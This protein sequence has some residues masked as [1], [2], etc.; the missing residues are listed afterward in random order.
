[1]KRLPPLTELRAFEAAA[2]HL[3]F[4]RAA[5]ELGVTPTA[6]SHQI[7]LLEQYCGKPLFRRRP[8]PMAL[9]W[10][11]QQLFPMVRDGFESFATA[12]AAVRA[13]S[14]SGG[15][16][17]TSTNALAARWLVP[18]LPLWRKEFPGIRLSIVGTDAVLDLR[19]GEADVA[20][21]YA[22]TPPSDM[23][24]VELARDT[25]HVVGSRSL[26]GVS[27]KAARPS[28]L[29]RFPIIECEWPPTDFGAPTWERWE[30]AARAK[31]RKVPSL[32]TSASF[33]FREELHAIE[34]VI[35]GQGIAILSDILV[36]RELAN[37]TLIRLSD[38]T[39][40]G[41][42]FFAVYRHG[43]PKRAAIQTLVSWI[44]SRV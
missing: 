32:A 21:R 43:H 12:L 34:A 25:F 10:S 1:M 30:E 40:P 6:I 7:R 27:R 37:G 22:R 15:L 14:A 3:S 41:Y 16:R 20:I 19:S 39:L 2:R 11:G 18:R 33:S 28:D 9:T 44:G 17:V 29:A 42:G 38:I 8:R 13:G 26:V 36:G 4:S 35:A 23:V 31:K 24:W 5:T